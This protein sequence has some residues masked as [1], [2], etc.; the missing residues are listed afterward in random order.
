MKQGEQTI[1][2]LF[3]LTKAEVNW[4]QNYQHENKLPSENAVI[5]ILIRDKIKHKNSVIDGF[6]ANQKMRTI[7]EK[8]SDR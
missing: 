7:L 1:K 6:F 8:L 3:T 5:K 4:L 2:K